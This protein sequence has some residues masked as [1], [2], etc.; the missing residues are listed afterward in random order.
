MEGGMSREGI[1]EIP[2]WGG[3]GKVGGWGKFPPR[4]GGIPEIPSR[5]E[6]ST[7]HPL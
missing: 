3:G 7:A 6:F 4:E 1:P 2:S 5:Y